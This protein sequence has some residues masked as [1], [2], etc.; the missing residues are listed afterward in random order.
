M[1]KIGG[2]R[3]PDDKE[4]KV[5][6]TKNYKQFKFVEGNRDIDHVNKI[7][8]S[9]QIV[10]LFVQPI[11]VNQR[12]EIIDGQH[13]FSACK[14]LELPI[15]YIV[16]DDVGL[17]EV[18]ALNMASKNWSTKDFIKSYA[19]GNHQVDYVYLQQLMKAYPW[20]TVK[21]L[22]CAFQWQT[23]GGVYGKVKD[24]EFKCSAE[25][26]QSAMN[27]LEYLNLVRE[28]INTVTGKKE[29]Y[30]FAIVFCYFCEL[31]DNEYLLKKINKYYRSLDAATSIKSAMMQLESKVYNYQMRTP[32]EPVSIS[33]E[34]EKAARAKK[35]QNRRKP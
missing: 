11:L 10:G 21:I 17:E 30:Y 9:I 13:R 34:Y 33:I 20:A 27:A 19:T 18:K 12:M 35:Q 29:H 4:Y 6:C 28:Q 3:I 15:Y 16:Q 23:G 31:V 1:R 14:E 26:Y 2:I 22:V 32:M 24:G 5:R 8:K 25:Q 7:I